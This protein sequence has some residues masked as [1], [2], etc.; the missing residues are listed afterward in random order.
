MPGSVSDVY[1]ITVENK[2]DIAVTVTAEVTD[3]A[4]S[5]LVNGLKLDGNSWGS[6]TAVIGKRG[7]LKS[8]VRLCV[9]ENYT[10]FS[11]KSGN[12]TFWAEEPP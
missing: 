9:A 5:L 11:V 8:K 6:F 1:V 3:Q 10:G 4:Q 12:L 2:G 7:L